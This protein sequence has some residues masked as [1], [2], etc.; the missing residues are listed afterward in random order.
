MLLTRYDDCI[1]IPK[2]A[3]ANCGTIHFW[4]GI[5]QSLT[6]CRT[7]IANYQCH[8]LPTLATQRQPNPG[9]IAFAEHK[10]PEFVELE[11]GPIRIPMRCGNERLQVWEAGYFFLIQALMVVRET[12]KVRARPRRLL[13]S[14]EARKI[15]SRRACDV[16]WG[17]G[18][19]RLCRP[20]ARQRYFCLPLGA[21]PF[22]MISGLP[23]CWHSRVM[24]T[25]QG[26]S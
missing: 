10:R 26:F 5:P 2:V 21:C 7:A 15:S 12:L 17:V 1:G 20:H 3:V 9:L 8:D 11:H 18:F 22:L 16:T 6:T 25:I 23:Q 14:W 13:R 4:N 19:S 24:T